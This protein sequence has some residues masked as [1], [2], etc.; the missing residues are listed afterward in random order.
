MAIR[1][2]IRGVWR[3]SGE[4]VEL[5][6]ESP[7]ATGAETT[8]NSRGILVA[9]CEPILQQPPLPTPTV[10][11]PTSVGRKCPHCGSYGVG[12]V[13]G[14]QG[15]SE[16]MTFLVLFLFLMLPA[17]IYYIYMESLPYCS[18]CGRRVKARLT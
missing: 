15:F 16:I 5:V 9:S 14:L 8:A 1:W 2:Q 18:G 11:S 10:A 13:R 7:T 4:D 3:D 6:I 12:T 17:V